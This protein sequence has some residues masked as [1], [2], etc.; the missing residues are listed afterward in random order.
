[1]VPT[2]M[3]IEIEV[4]GSEVRDEYDHLYVDDGQK[5]DNQRRPILYRKGSWD[6]MEIARWVS[7]W[8]YQVGIH[9]KSIMK[10]RVKKATDGGEGEWIRE[11]GVW[12]NPN[13]LS[14]CRVDSS[15]FL[16]FLNPNG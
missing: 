11:W 14:F 12:M 8:T 6:I 9:L 2:D 10:Q 3:N 1:M 16:V 15:L 4:A 5:K 7:K 13:T